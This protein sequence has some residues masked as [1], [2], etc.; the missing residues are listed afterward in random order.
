MCHVTKFLALLR[1]QGPRATA[2]PPPETINA[3][4]MASISVRRGKLAPS[5]R[6][7]PA[8]AYGASDTN[9]RVGV[10]A[11]SFGVSK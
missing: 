11:P 5:A 3:Y 7:K 1:L 4:I 9:W 6:K 2:S 10:D 8:G